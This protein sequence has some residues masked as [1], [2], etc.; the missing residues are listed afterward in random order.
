M[1]YKLF[2]NNDFPKIGIISLENSGENILR[3]YLEKIF[4]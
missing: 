3:Y 1:S 2:P 4:D